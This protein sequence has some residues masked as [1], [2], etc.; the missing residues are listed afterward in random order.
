[1]SLARRAVFSDFWMVMA[2]DI[3]FFCRNERRTFLPNFLFVALIFIFLK[4]F[5]RKDSD[6][7]SRWRLS[8]L[9]SRVKNLTDS[10]RVFLHYKA[11]F[12]SC[13]EQRNSLYFVYPFEALSSPFMFTH[14]LATN[15]YVS[16]CR[17]SFHGPYLPSALR[18]ESQ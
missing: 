2:L 1:M 17:M 6:L 14:L 3:L 16:S 9:R 12:T 7:L 8:I 11:D 4:D 10:L 15:L 18:M 13:K 5:D